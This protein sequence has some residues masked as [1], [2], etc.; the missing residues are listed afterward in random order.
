MTFPFDLMGF[1]LS[2]LKLTHTTNRFTISFTNKLFLTRLY[3]LYQRAGPTKRTSLALPL[4]DSYL[5][6]SL[7]PFEQCNFKSHELCLGCL[8][9]PFPAPSPSSPVLPPPLPPQSHTALHR[10]IFFYLS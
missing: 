6:L 8:G 9:L 1:S 3:Q 4:S 2:S 10:Y 5:S 7:S